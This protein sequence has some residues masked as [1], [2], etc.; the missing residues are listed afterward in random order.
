M[1][2]LFE[3]PEKNSAIAGMQRRLWARGVPTTSRFFAGWCVAQH[4]QRLKGKQTKIKLL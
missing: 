3:K 2:K 4:Q 1:R